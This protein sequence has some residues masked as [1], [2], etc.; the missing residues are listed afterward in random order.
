[1]SAPLLDLDLASAAFKRDPHPTYA[2]LRAE[3]P[4]ARVRMRGPVGRGAT[5]F[6]VARY[7]DVSALLK[8]ARLAK[9]PVSAGLSAPP[10]PPFLRPL[11]RNMLGLDDP[12]HARLKRLVQATFTP[13]RIETMRAR[14][15]AISARLLDAIDATQPF[16]LVARYALPLPVAVISDL[17]GV[18]AADQARF[19]R[20]SGALIRAGHSSLGAALAMPEVIAFLAYVDHLIA[21]KRRAPADDLV[22]ALIAAADADDAR[23]SGDELKAMIGILLSAGH[24]TTVNLI[25]N[26]ALALI[27][28]AEAMA[29]LRGSPAIMENAIE[30]LLRFAGPV[31]MSTHRYAREDLAIAGIEI[32]RGAV[33]FGLIASA[34]R[35]ADRFAAPDRLDLARTG[36]RHLTFGEGGHYCVG[37]ALA[38][39][40]AA[41]AFAD[42]LQRFPTLMLAEPRATVRASGGMILSGLARLRVRGV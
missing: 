38:R 5:A 42:L 16:D 15:Q 1:M 28:D 26:G 36:N 29:S 7:A 18:P 33:V 25:A 22:S 21:L 9:D 35:D 20:W 31:A 34:N 40:E 27:D 12:D 37:A 4:V 14:T 13:R 24:E 2:R 8:D 41:V 6:I 10:A 39:M 23:L 3:T 19:A 17:L 11:F 32:P 30:E